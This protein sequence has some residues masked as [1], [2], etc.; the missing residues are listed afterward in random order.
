MVVEVE[1]GEGL[2]LRL[3]AGDRVAVVSTPVFKSCDNRQTNKEVEID[4]KK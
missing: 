1:V 2:F 3:L 4:R